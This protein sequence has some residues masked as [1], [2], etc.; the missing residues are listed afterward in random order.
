[1]GGC[2]ARVARI[3]ALVVGSVGINCLDA[4]AQEVVPDSYIVT[5]HADT[6][7]ARSLEA[8][9]FST[10]AM[11]KR[12]GADAA[13]LR[14][15]QAA[16][17]VSAGGI[18]S[19][20]MFGRKQ[21]DFC[22]DLINRRDDIASCSPNW[23]LR[24]SAVP[25]DPR[26]SSLWGMTGTSGV[27]ANAAWDTT[28]GSDSVV[29]AVID[30]GIDYNHQ[31]LSGN[32]WVNPLEIPN[33]GIDDDG[34]GVVDDVHGVNFSGNGRPVGDP[35]DDNSHGT[36]VAGTIGAIGNN[37][38]GVVGVNWRVK[39]MGL[40][41]LG[42]NGSGSTAGAVQAINYLV[43]LKNRGINVRV[44]N[45]SWGGGGDSPVLREAIQRAD[46]AGILFTAAA[47]N[48]GQNIDE[49]PQYPAAY[50]LANMLK[51]AAIDREG[52][53]AYFSNYGARLV[54]V[55]A[56]GVDILSTVP[57]NQYASYS[58][59]SMA[60]PHVSGVAALYLSNHPNASVAE[61]KAAIIGGG[62]ELASLVGLTSTGRT[63][64]AQRAVLDISVPVQA[65]AAEC[66]YDIS[67]QPYSV[68]T[69]SDR[70]R[71]VV[72]SDEEGFYR[73]S[74]PFSFPFEGQF[75]ES[76]YLS[77]N[78]VV[79]FGSRPTAWDNRNQST[80]PVNS[81][82]ALHTDLYPDPEVASGLGVRVATSGSKVTV[83]WKARVYD[84]QSESEQVIVRLTLFPSGVI[85]IGYSISSAG[86]RTALA[87]ATIG[88]KGNS[89]ASSSTYGGTLF[90]GLRLRLTPGCQPSR[91]MGTQVKTVSAVGVMNKQERSAAI[92]GSKI[93]L[94]GQITGQGTVQ[95]IS[96]ID[97]KRCSKNTVMQVRERK[98]K[99]FGRV[100]FGV[101]AKRI[102]FALVGDDGGVR[103]AALR[104]RS[105]SKKSGAKR[106][107]SLRSSCDALMNSFN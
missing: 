40:K 10:T 51:V 102:S 35:F 41:F 33:N 47:G 24:A 37:A 29:V 90:D 18:S 19:T 71:A 8:T 1:M 96:R 58:G 17:S 88:V 53:L 25:S 56:P 106:A 12:I 60:T 30:T 55:A 70:K 87:T 23:V 42:A 16:H 15:P 93:V 77:P 79:Y 43:D 92:A 104:I 31:D 3:A 11:E 84:R 67:Q 66:P 13:V 57:G 63:V 64:D 50:T 94:R 101:V 73:V 68:D 28:T 46:T 62:R 36:H 91:G 39:L 14:G 52:N 78:G 89:L 98:L 86:L 75:R 81:I 21:I 5:Y 2:L 26:L 59:T 27:A 69:A 83:S 49:I 44:V 20:E 9:A 100:P 45:N 85:D 38:V 61:V 105:K 76:M 95:L 65:P 99:R 74:L 32:V 54:D 97:G 82:A 103:V 107:K 34:N 7:Q 6:L 80:A 72:T 48:S 22:N 4:V